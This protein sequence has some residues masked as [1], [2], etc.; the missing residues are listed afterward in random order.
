ML[1]TLGNRKIAIGRE[2]TK[3]YEEI[4]RGN[5]ESAI[6]RFSEDVVRGEFV[7]IVE[8]NKEVVVVEVNIEQ[9]LIRHIENGLSKKDAIQKIVEEKKI[10]KNEV[11]KE[12][13]KLK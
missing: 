5:F 12:S 7:I 3:H 11:Y 10:P 8:G 13:L 1:N 6:Q 4:F 2:I 9:E